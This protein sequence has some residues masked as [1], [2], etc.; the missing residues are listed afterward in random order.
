MTTDRFCALD[1]T[2]EFTVKYSFGVAGF[3]T[4]VR[5]RALGPSR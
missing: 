3:T 2:V 1:A 4:A 5:E